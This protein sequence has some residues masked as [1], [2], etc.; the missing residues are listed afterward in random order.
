MFPPFLACCVEL[1][2]ACGFFDMYE[3]C[4]E[5]PQ[6]VLVG[7]LQCKMGKKELLISKILKI[8]LHM[9]PNIKE[10]EGLAYIATLKYID[11]TPPDSKS[12]PVLEQSHTL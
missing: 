4:Y 7:Y 5:H 2:R 1:E 8:M 3:E 11:I 12:L 9:R 6:F 10:E